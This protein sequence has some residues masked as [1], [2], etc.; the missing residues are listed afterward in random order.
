MLFKYPFSQLVR[1]L[2]DAPFNKKGLLFWILCPFLFFISFIVAGIG[3][4]RRYKSYAQFSDLSLPV[5]Q[6][7]TV[8]CIGNLLLGGTGKS[9]IV[10]KFASEYLKKGFIV[11]IASR[12]IGTPY[13][14]AVN[15]LNFHQTEIDQ[16]SDENREHFELLKHDFSQHQ[17]FIFQNPNRKASLYKYIQFISEMKNREC[18][19]ILDDGLQHFSCPR[20]FNICI[21]DTHLEKSTPKYAWPVGS[22]REGFGAHSIQK[23]LTSFDL[24]IWRE[25]L[26]HSNTLFKFP[27]DYKNY[28]G[29]RDLSA[30]YTMRFVRISV[31]ENKRFSFEYIDSKLIAD[32]KNHQEKLLLLAGI[33][34]P[35][36]FF[37]HLGEITKNFTTCDFCVLPDHGSLTQNCLKKIEQTDI[38]ILTLKDFFR[39]C[40]SNTFFDVCQNK[41]IYGCHTD[42]TIVAKQ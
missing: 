11:G 17:F 31:L 25:Q 39:F 35:D 1:K 3:Y 27:E 38:L 7:L 20:H 41:T 14:V 22:Y 40:T 15:S 10:R 34:Q 4:Y 23:I 29:N 13:C 9:P 8:I 12:G 21:C 37:S 16:L 32:T 42:Y 28:S 33:A 5:P 36:V 24:R 30:S 6:N 18:L 26:H 2:L 19:L